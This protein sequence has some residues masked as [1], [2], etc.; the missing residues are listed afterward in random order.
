VAGSAVPIDSANLGRTG[1]GRPP[2]GA[3]RQPAGGLCALVAWV[4]RCRRCSLML[5][6]ADGELVL[7]ESVGLPPGLT[8]TV[9]VGLGTGVAGTVASR[10]AP[11]VVNDIAERAGWP[12]G[13]GAY[14][15]PRFVSYPITLPGEGTGVVNVTDPEP[16]RGPFGPEDLELL[17]QLIRFYASTHDAPA[18]REVLRL[19]EELRAL[20]RESIRRQEAERQRLAR[21]VHDDAGHALTAAI[22]RLDTAAQRL[23][24]GGELAEALA[25]TRDALIECATHLQD[26]A[27]HLRPRILADLGLAPA[28]RSLARRVREAGE[29]DVG[30]EVTGEER[31]LDPEVELAAF[32]I[33]QEAVTNALKHAA[34]G[35][36]AIAVAFADGIVSI[37]IRDDGAGFDPAQPAV[38]DRR[39]GHGLHGMRE[40][41]ALAGGV[42]EVRS[43]PGRGSCILARLPAREP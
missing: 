20:R 37:E 22:L 42:V 13:V 3:P 14:P 28:L 23:L 2:R 27:F 38:A 17:E 25:S 30:V 1:R 18:R 15:S 33:A 8:G 4:L 43:T 29:V 21:E 16:G 7:E 12:A 6:G 32:R 5:A 36:V 24:S 40:R 41:A 31:R 9:R 35:R 10:G 11:L 19:R 34:A 39:S 26:V